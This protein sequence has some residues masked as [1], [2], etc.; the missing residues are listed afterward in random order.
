[1]NQTSS[2]TTT[3]GVFMSKISQRAAVEQATAIH[4]GERFQPGTDVK[5][6]ATKEDKHAIAL[7][8]AQGML[9]GAVELSS[10]ATQ[11]YALNGV[12]QLTK[13]YVVGMVTNWFNKSKTLNGGVVYQAKNPGS[14]T[15]S[16]EP[17]PE[18]EFFNIEDAI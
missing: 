2:P 8:V 10:E 7:I 17:Q 13:K 5:L 3:K 9:E 16:P 1:M 18:I 4:M 12:E 14:R 11:K 6:S 15:K